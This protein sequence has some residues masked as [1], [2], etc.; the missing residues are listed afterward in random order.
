M[1]LGPDRKV[2]SFSACRLDILRNGRGIEIEVGVHEGD[3]FPARRKR[4]CLDRVPLA[5]IPVVVDD[6]DVS[7]PRFQQAFGR[8]VDRAVRN[9]DDLDVF[10]A[11]TFRDYSPDHADVVDDL[12]TTVVDRHNDRH[13]RSR[14][15]L[16]R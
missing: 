11:E 16:L 15:R 8:T 3:P 5:E 10:A 9:D 14:S 13:E 1:A 7:T 12:L 2:Q 4:A 6:T